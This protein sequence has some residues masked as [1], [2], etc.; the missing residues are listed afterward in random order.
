MKN[1]KTTDKINELISSTNNSNE[2][3]EDDI[4][5]LIGTIIFSI[6]AMTIGILIAVGLS[7]R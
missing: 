7:S 3:K 6:V 2:I 5:G 1:Y 4:T